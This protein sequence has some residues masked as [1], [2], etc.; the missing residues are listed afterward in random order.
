MG[1]AARL[2]LGGVL[3]VAGALKL[4]ALGESVNAVMAYRLLPY[5]LVPVVGTA[6]PFV[7]VALGLLLLTGT[8]T[9]VAGILGGLVMVAFII[10]IAS[11]W[12]RGL[13]LDCGCFG[14]GGEISPEAARAAYPW[15]IARDV[16]L[17]ACGVWLALF[18]RT[19]F[20]VDNLRLPPAGSD[21]ALDPDTADARPTDPLTTA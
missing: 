8:Y 20:A 16:G 1:L 15:E 21:A 10:A 2:L 12:A 4:P 18:P 17:L 6:L 14:G 7:E 13:S 5:D 19:R 9:R 11:A 3:L